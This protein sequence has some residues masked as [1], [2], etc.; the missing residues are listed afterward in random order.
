M[1]LLNDNTFVA[2]LHAC[3]FVK[4]VQHTNIYFVLDITD[5]K[6]LLFRLPGNKVNSCDR[7]LIQS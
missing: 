3:N 7:S 4:S 1:L 6:A 5:K 2:P